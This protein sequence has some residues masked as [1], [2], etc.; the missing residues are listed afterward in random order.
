MTGRLRPLIF[1]GMRL[2]SLALVLACISGNQAGKE[3]APPAQQRTSSRQVEA[4]TLSREVEAGPLASAAAATGPD[5]GDLADADAGDTG[6]CAKDADCAFTRVGAGDCCAM[7]CAPR[8]VTRRRAKEL[9]DGIARCRRGLC[10][11]PVCARPREISRAVCEEKKC[12]A[13]PAGRN[14]ID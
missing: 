4:G 7:L 2:A 5:G 14:A 9:E 13:K 1:P 6:P 8:A 11:D 12:V 3:A 10:P